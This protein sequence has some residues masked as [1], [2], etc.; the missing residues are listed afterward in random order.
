MRLILLVSIPLAAASAVEL[1]VTGVTMTPK[2]AVVVRSGTLPA[3]DTL[4]S[5][6]PAN[7]ASGPLL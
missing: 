2:G 7:A 6:I 3:G 5:G 4:V 1:P